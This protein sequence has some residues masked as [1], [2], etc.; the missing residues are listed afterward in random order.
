MA[1]PLLAVPVKRFYVAKRR[2]SSVLDGP[3]R[4]RLGRNLAAHTL[5]IVRE[6]GLEPIVLAADNEVARWAAETGAETMLDAGAGLDDA[7]SAVAGR[8]SGEGRRWMVVHADLPL[9]TAAE[10]TE[11]VGVLASG[12]SV[13]APSKDGGTSLIG[14]HRPLS[15]SYGPGSFQRHLGALGGPTV[16]VR[17][18]LALDLDDATDLA[19]ALRHPRGEWLKQYAPAS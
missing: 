14:G 15:F 1:P 4:S 7:C 9:L 16:L 12:A 5:A 2:L 8:A 11:A 17:L 19:A 3:A 18:G 13:V 10:V 6:A